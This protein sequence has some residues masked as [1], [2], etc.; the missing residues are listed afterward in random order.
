MWTD[1]ILTD[2][3][4]KLSAASRGE[5]APLTSPQRL[6]IFLVDVIWVGVLQQHLLPLFEYGYAVLSLQS[7]EG[8]R[9]SALTSVK[10]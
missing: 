3:E 9:S 10:M 2:Y 8:T 4:T 1:D 5:Q 6:D 7:P